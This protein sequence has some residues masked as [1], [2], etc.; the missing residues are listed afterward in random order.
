MISKSFLKSDE[1][2]DFDSFFK[3]VAI[4]ST[5]TLLEKII[6]LSGSIFAVYN[7]RGDEIFK[8]V[9]QDNLKIVKV[10]DLKNFVLLVDESGGVFIVDIYNENFQFKKLFE[11]DDIVFFEKGKRDEFYLLNKYGWFLELVNNNYNF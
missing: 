9:L 4:L 3:N 5:N 8:L 1:M 2:T 11:I 7:L 6:L 10:F